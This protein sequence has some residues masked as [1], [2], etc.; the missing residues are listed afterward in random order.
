MSDIFRPTSCKKT[1]MWHEVPT[2]W[3][4]EL[5]WYSF[6][7]TVLLYTVIYVTVFYYSI[8]LGRDIL[9]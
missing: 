2:F 8:L 1:W 9:D 3:K 5:S 7:I 6:I 4:F